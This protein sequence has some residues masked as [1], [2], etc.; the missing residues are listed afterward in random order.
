M[1]K[2]PVYALLAA[3]LILAAGC[4]K[5][6]KSTTYADAKRYIDAWVSVNYPGVQA[7]EDGIY[8]LEEVE[9]TGSEVTDS[10]FVC[11]EYTAY[12][13][14]GTVY[15]SS[16]A[17]IARQLGLFSKSGYFGGHWW[18]I[19]NQTQQVGTEV[20]LKGMKIGGERTFLCPR[21]LVTS[22]R[23][24]TVDEYLASSSGGSDD[25]IYRF[26]VIDACDS[27]LVY[28]KA[29]IREFLAANYPEAKEIEDGFYYQ[30]LREPVDTTSFPSD[31]T[32]TINYV[33]RL[34]NGQVF[35]T[36]IADTAK[37]Y[38]IYSSSRSYST[39]S[40]SWATE[41]TSLKLGTSSVIS[42][43]SKT[44][45]QMRPME[46]GVG[47]FTSDKGYAS[48]GSG[49]SIPEYSPLVFEIDIVE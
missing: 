20:G 36:T 29:R 17:E 25:F 40:V 43:F 41:A 24:N 37:V 11:V 1:R 39:T 42:G 48:T 45:W 47:I 16:D 18:Q 30:Q 9:G 6:E 15:E 38:N 35:D 14:D 19:A 7:N 28:Q 33:G 4:A 3:I 32:I 13:L 49:E 8:I 23:H 46:K 26:K 31:T 34:L 5:K 21:W 10:A 44:L 12:N 22:E 27:I 2:L